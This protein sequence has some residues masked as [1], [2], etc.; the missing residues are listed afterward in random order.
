MAR[1]VD[2]DP[3]LPDSYRLQGGLQLPPSAGLERS[4][5]RS[6]LLRNIIVSVLAAAAAAA[7]VFLY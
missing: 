7:L 4:I 1:K 6:P 5:R 2:C 3:R